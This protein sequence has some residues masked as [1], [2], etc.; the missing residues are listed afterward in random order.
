MQM[1]KIRGVVHIQQLPCILNVKRLQN[2][3]PYYITLGI[4]LT[5]NSFKL[6]TICHYI[7]AVLRVRVDCYRHR[8]WS[9]SCTGP[10]S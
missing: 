10:C 1:L 3:R 5:W 8:T 7:G 6:N 4:P 2:L 9:L